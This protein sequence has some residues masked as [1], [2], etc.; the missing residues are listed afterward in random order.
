VSVVSAGMSRLSPNRSQGPVPR[1]LPVSHERTSQLI[2][3]TREGS[4]LLGP[5]LLPRRRAVTPPPSTRPGSPGRSWEA[6]PR[7]PLQSRMVLK[8][9]A[10]TERMTHCRRTTLAQRQEVTSSGKVQVQSPPRLS[11]ASPRQRRRELEFSPLRR[12]AR[13]PL[14]AD[15]GEP[16]SVSTTGS[17]AGFSESEMPCCDVRTVASPS[18]AHLQRNAGPASIEAAY[19]SL[20]TPVPQDPSGVALAKVVV[21]FRAGDANHKG[22]RVSVHGRTMDEIH[23]RATRLLSNHAYFRVR[24]ILDRYLRVVKCASDLVSGSRYLACTS[25][26]RPDTKNLHHFWVDSRV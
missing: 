5:T 24:R 25:D 13:A 14:C 7:S 17:R 21:L 8:G 1:T 12:G 11:A 18:V 4:S 19:G 20:V 9:P 10:S 22:T 23:K 6:P 26:D 2:L 15:A 16:D 3:E